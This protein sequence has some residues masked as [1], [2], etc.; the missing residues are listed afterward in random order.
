MIASA[1]GERPEAPKKMNTNQR[2]KMAIRSM[3]RSRTTE[4]SRE[5][6][7]SRSQRL[8]RYGLASSPTRP[9]TRPEMVKET[10]MALKRE[11]MGMPGLTSLSMTLH[12]TALS[13]META[14]PPTAM[15][16]QR[17]DASLASA[18][19]FARWAFLRKK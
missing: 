8:S 18:Q 5:P 10:S 16:I 1:S 19:T 2:M 11:L 15:R 4:A 13:T 9:G 14:S 7:G 3:P 6:K 12:R 17:S